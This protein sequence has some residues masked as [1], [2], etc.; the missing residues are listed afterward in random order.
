MTEPKTL[1]DELLESMGEALAHARGE[2]NGTRITHA[3][4]SKPSPDGTSGPHGYDGHDD[5]VE[6]DGQRVGRLEVAGGRLVFRSAVAQTRHLDGQTF[7]DADSARR[8]AAEACLNRQTRRG[9]A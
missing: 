7:D 1:G 3:E 9:R 4:V 8:R 5:I 6:V 2:N